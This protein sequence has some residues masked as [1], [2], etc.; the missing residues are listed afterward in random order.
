MTTETKV[1]FVGGGKGALELLSHF[2][3]LGFSLVGVVDPSPEA[4]AMREAR[5]LNVPTFSRIEDL[6]ARKPDLIMEVTGR[7]EVARQVEA[8]KTPSMGLLR[9]QDA[10]FLYEVIAREAERQEI[11]AGQIRELGRVKEEI[12]AVHAP[13]RD[14]F[15]SLVTGNR[16]VEKALTPLTKGM[17]RMDQDTHRSDELVAAIHAIAR[18]TKMLGLNASIEAARAGDQGK[19][20]A[21]VAEEVR[22]LAEQTTTAVQEVATTLTRIAGETRAMREPVDAMGEMIRQRL[23]AIEALNS[24]VERLS[25]LLTSVEE[26]E[27]RLISLFGRN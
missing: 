15:E 5:K 8:L 2:S 19:G 21:V 22:K 27:A 13:L 10:K 4:P 20:F 11:L 16:E 25:S 1:G 7:E 23:S 26:I 6:V 12:A 24:R 17:E 9:S 14:S 3:R 18:Q